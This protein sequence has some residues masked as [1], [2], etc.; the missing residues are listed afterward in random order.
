MKSFV[1]Y[2]LVC[3]IAIFLPSVA[4]AQGSTDLDDHILF[5][6][7]TERDYV[8]MSDEHE[9]SD[10]SDDELVLIEV[11]PIT[12]IVVSVTEYSTDGDLKSGSPLGSA[13]KLPDYIDYRQLSTFTW[14]GTSGGGG[15][16]EEP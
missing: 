3:G 12:L 14:S 11:D 15:S 5:F 8:I 1:L 13:Y 4:A 7:M 10:P 9:E 2:C 16:W 6:E